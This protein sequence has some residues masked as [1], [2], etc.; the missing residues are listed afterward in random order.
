[1]FVGT[2]E[3]LRQAQERAAQ[4]AQQIADLLDRLDAVHTGS[5]YGQVRFLGGEIRTHR[6]HWT[7]HT[8][9]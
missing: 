9:R 6:G 2:P 5:T 4:L 7:V 3:Q 8:G 1:M